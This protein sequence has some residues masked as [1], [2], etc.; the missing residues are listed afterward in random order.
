VIFHFLLNDL[1]SIIGIREEWEMHTVR[2]RFKAPGQRSLRRFTTSV[3]T[4]LSLFICP[5]E[6]SYGEDTEILRIGTMSLP[7]YGFSSEDG[8]NKGIVYE[9]LQEIGRRSGLPFTNYILPFKRMLAMLENSR[10]DLIS[11]Q[12]H[13]DAMKAGEKLAHQF[14]INVILIPK[15]NVHIRSLEDVKDKTIIFHSGASYPQLDHIE[16]NTI[17]VNDYRQSLQIL[18][19]R[20]GIDGAVITEPA[21]LYWMKELGL[22]PDDFGEPVMVE[23]DKEQWIFVR[24]DMPSSTKKMLK[25]I[26]EDLYHEQYYEQLLNAYRQ[27]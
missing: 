27:K 17:E 21:F 11:S 26:T 12:A 6:N 4:I 2:H 10:L 7:P 9:H 24:K 8:R 13:Q 5:L 25:A 14:S 20:E 19:S 22:S 15:K 1:Q 18:Q 16:K 23:K 3:F